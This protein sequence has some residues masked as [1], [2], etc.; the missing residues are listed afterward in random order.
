MTKPKVAFRNFVYM[1]EII[2]S[3]HTALLCFFVWTS[4]QTAIIYVYRVT[5]FCNTDGECLL[6]GMKLNI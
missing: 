6:R 1:P 3:A 4:E 2:L 5:G